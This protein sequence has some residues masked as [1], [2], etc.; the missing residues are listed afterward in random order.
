MVSTQFYFLIPGPQWFPDFE[1]L[2][3]ASKASLNSF[4]PSVL[5]NSSSLIPSSSSLDS[6]SCWTY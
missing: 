1:Q 5:L 6:E 2:A 4:H 3:C